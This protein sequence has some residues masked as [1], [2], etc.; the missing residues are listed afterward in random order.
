MCTVDADV[1]ELTVP[2]DLRYL[3]VVRRSLEAVCRLHGFDDATT[4][5]VVLASEEACSNICRHAYGGARSGHIWITYR[6]CDDALEIEFVDE[7]KSFCPNAADQKDPSELRP[8]GRGLFLIREI[9]DDVT[10]QPRQPRGTRLRMRKCL[11][12]DGPT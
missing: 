1:L 3:R 11:P 7:G 8:G 9:M 6:L 4:G 10:Y 5:S 12:Q 2:S